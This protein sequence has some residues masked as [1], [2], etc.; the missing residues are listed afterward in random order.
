MR[1]NGVGI[2]AADH[3]LIF[4]RFRQVGDA[5]TGKPQ[6]TGLGLPISRQIIAH[7]GGR[8]WVASAAR[9]RRDL[10][11]HAPVAAAVPASG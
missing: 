3:E 7:L 8:L 5:L 4:E 1:D 2:D 10:L 9:P 11:V 6:G